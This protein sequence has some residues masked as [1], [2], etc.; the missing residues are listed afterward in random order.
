MRA[1]RGCRP[2]GS[3]PSQRYLYRR[4]RTPV[5]V[6]HFGVQALGVEHQHD[7]AFKCVDRMQLRPACHPIRARAGAYA[8]CRTAF[9]W[10]VPYRVSC[11]QTDRVSRACHRAEPSRAEP[12]RA[13]PSRAEPSRA[14]PSRRAYTV[15]QF[16]NLHKHTHQHHAGIALDSATHACVLK[17]SPSTQ[18]H[19]LIRTPSLRSSVT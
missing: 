10:C 7:V 9:Q 1:P 17:P 16:A 18:P 14:E 13:E 8:A 6:A 15:F 12:S 4:R 11:G 19:V 3:H 2:G 5:M